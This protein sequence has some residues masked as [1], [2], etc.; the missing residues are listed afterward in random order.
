MKRVLSADASLMREVPHGSFSSFKYAYESIFKGELM[1]IQALQRPITSTSEYYDVD[2]KKYK[3][4]LKRL[5]KAKRELNSVHAELLELFV[6][7]II[8]ENHSPWDVYTKISRLNKFLKWLE[9]NNKNITN[10]SSFDVSRYLVHEINPSNRHRIATD[11]KRFIRFLKEKIDPSYEL[12]Y[13]SFK[14]KKPREYPLPPLP[15]DELLEL[16][17]KHASTFY[18]ALFTVLYEG[19][20]RLGEALS[21]KLRHVEDHEDYIKIIVSKSKSMQRAVYIVKYQ[22]CLREWLVEHPWKNLP[23]AYLFPART[24][25]P[26][27]QMNRT[28]IY[29]YIMR[30]KKR[31]GINTRFYPHLLRHKRATELYKMMS[32]KEMMI[33][34]GWKT[35][36]MLDVYAHI[37]QKDVEEKVLS[38]YGLDNNSKMANEMICPRCGAK[39]PAEANYCWICGTPLKSE[40]IASLELDKRRLRELIVRLLKQ[41]GSEI[42]EELS[43]P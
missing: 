4:A 11:I 9:T 3:E 42:L 7:D 37:V 23:D 40:V 30:L 38:L 8:A 33:Y 17:F 32:E 1:T 20:L 13:N 29:N 39:N 41:F 2:V 14:V 5:E 16:I 43:N 34:F 12:L 19:G 26:Y 21:I 35:R 18:K 22:K 6:Y 24:K 28:T 10:C 15:P 31:L 25:G 27:H 36:E